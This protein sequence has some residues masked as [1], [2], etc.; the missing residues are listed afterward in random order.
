LITIRRIQTGEA[1]LFKQMRLKSLQDAPY[2]FSTNYASAIQRSAESWHEQAES[3][4]QGS[5][6]ATFIAFS[7]AVPV[8]IAA[9]Y[10]LEGQTEAGEVLQVWIAPEFRSTGIAWDLMDVLFQWARENNFRKI[11]AGVTKENT[12]ALKFY[13]RYGFSVMDESLP[14]DADGLSLVK[15]VS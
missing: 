2:A 15:E 5:D 9:L 11:I 14:N 8:G 7:E 12:R 4:A 3:T 13:T 10:R 1:D 6:R